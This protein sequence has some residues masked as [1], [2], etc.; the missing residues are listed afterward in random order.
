MNII[1]LDTPNGL[2]KGLSDAF[3]EV[4]D[5]AHIERVTSSDSLIETLESDGD[6]ELVVLDF[7]EGD[8]KTGEKL[9]SAIRQVFPAQS[10]SG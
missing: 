5:D 7:V 3:T 10:T 2:L 4:V 8:G 6:W 1:M 9:I